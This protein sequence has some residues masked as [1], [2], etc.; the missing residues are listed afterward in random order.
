MT[1]API[2][3][4]N[5]K[6]LGFSSHW[7]PRFLNIKSQVTS[8]GAEIDLALAG[9]PL[10]DF[11]LVYHFLRDA[12]PTV[13]TSEYKTLFGFFLAMQGNLNRFAYQNP[14]DYTVTGQSIGTGDG[15]TTTFT[16]QRTYGYSNTGTEPIGWLNTAATCNVYVSSVLKTLGTDYTLS[17][18]VGTLQQVV[19]AS[20]PA[21]SAPITVDMS[22]FYNCKFQQPGMDFE[23]FMNQ[24]WS[25]QKITLRS[26]RAYA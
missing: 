16:L 8:S 1:G 23:K 26:C 9:T 25:A 15:S 22:Y 7:K 19:F 18:T 21:A 5:L 11:E 13:G 4:S 3:P 17:T 6:G 2:Y 24:L 12:I 10:H 20:A 14:D